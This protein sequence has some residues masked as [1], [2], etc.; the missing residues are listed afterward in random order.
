MEI[1]KLK[2]L[3]LLLLVSHITKAQQDSAGKKSWFEQNVIIGQSLSTIT[4][5][6]KDPAQ[7]QATFPK[8]DTASYLV[9]LGVS[10]VL[11][12][13]ARFQSK[14]T[15]EFHRNTTT[16]SAQNNLQLGYGFFAKLSPAKSLGPGHWLFGDAKYIYDGVA[17]TNS[18]ASDLFYTL[19]LDQSPIN[20]NSTTFLNTTKTRTLTIAPYVGGQVQDVFAA[21]NDSA[22][23]FIFRPVFSTSV[24]FSFNHLLALEKQSQANAHPLV[25]IS[26]SYT[27]RWDVYNATKM[28]EGYTYLFN[29]ALNYYILTDPVNIS[30]GPSFSIGSDPMQG[31]K[32]QQYWLLS[33]NVSKFVGK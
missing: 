3:A 22:K 20:L 15:G 11:N 31:L 12:G 33:L 30:I 4:N 7:F 19:L 16:D 8:K 21:S 29:A 18:F 9:N 28:S 23:G 27:G 1:R 2:V 14:L 13:N 32:Q 17:I 6:T 26:A 10:V 25:T 5:A 24:L